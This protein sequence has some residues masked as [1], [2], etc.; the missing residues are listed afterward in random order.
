MKWVRTFVYWKAVE[1]IL[2]RELEIF[3]TP[4]ISNNIM[5]FAV[6]NLNV[7]FGHYISRLVSFG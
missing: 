6:D 3:Q 5:R 7:I 2:L 4:R 1:N